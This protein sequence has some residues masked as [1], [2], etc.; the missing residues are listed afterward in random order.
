[1]Q[2]IGFWVPMD[3]NKNYENEL[4]YILAFPSREGHDKSWKEFSADP[5]WVKV[6]Q[7]SEKDGKLVEKIDSDSRLATGIDYLLD[8][9]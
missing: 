5:E 3:K 1:M 4:V 8:S 9:A 6:K 2:L 7:E